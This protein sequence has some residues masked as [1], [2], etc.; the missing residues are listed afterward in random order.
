MSSNIDKFLGLLNMA[1]AVTVDD[2]AMLTGIVAEKIG[3][4]GS[5]S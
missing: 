3:L 1:S 2:G 4:R 5:R